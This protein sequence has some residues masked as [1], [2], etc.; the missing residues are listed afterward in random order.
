VAVV[1]SM[2]TI[3]ESATNRTETVEAKALKWAIEI[4]GR[5]IKYI[6]SEREKAGGCPKSGTRT[7]RSQSLTDKNLWAR[8]NPE[9]QKSG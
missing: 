6:V 9:R 4:G 7:I 3:E 1:A 5:C 2:V 8:R